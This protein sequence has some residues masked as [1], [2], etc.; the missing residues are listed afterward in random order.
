MPRTKKPPGTAADRRN[1]RQAALGTPTQVVA[2]FDLPEGRPWR[3]E[4]CDA[5]RAFWADPVAKVLQEV[6]RVLLLRWAEHLD[7]AADLIE[8]ADLD[9]VA[10]GSMG[11]PVENPRYGIAARSVATV[12]KCEAQLGVGALNRARLGIAIV[13]GQAALED[14]NARYLPPAPDSEEDDDPRRG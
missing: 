7:R 4:T 2:Y 6:D 11:Q 13:S 1:G 8:K 10:K 3:P 5:W 12:E 9:P 14:L